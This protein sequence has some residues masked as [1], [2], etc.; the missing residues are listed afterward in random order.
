MNRGILCTLIGSLFVIDAGGSLMWR[1]LMIPSDPDG[2]RPPG[3]RD[4]A[5][6]FDPAGNGTVVLF[7]GRIMRSG[8]L[9]AV[10]DTWIYTTSNRKRVYDTVV[11]M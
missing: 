10:A 5:L 4:A 11:A 2:E 1:H 6:G 9:V 7:G 8:K 3:T